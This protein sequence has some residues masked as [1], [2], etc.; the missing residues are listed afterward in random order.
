MKEHYA[1]RHY[2]K[3][4][5]IGLNILHYRKERG[6]TQMELAEMTGYSRNQIQRV[7]SAYVVPNIG[8]LYDI[9]EALNVPIEKLLEQR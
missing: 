4:V 1:S 6:V 5:Q 7:E 2:K 9:S 3:Y 8:I